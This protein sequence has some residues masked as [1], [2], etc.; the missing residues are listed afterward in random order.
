VVDLFLHPLSF[1]DP[2]GHQPAYGGYMPQP[3]AVGQHDPY[4]GF[5]QPLSIAPQ[6]GG[7]IAPQQGGYV[8]Q[9]VAVSQPIAV[10]PMSY[11]SQP[12]AVAPMSTAPVQKVLIEAAQAYKE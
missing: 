6:Q 3:V 2:R 8:S 9:P 4:A 7:Y 11:V 10:A 12:V 1:S 5:L